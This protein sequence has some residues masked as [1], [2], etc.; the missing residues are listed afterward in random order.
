MYRGHPQFVSIFE[1]GGPQ[2]AGNRCR[3]ETCPASQGV[4]ILRRMER[5]RESDR[6]G[7][8]R[9]NDTHHEVRFGN[10]HGRRLVILHTQTFIAKRNLSCAN[11][12]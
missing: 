3:P 9:Q 11:V 2:D 12:H 8:Q 1:K 10:V 7:I 5:A 6:D 4:D